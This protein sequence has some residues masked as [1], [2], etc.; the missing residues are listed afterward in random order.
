MPEDFFL[1]ISIVFIIIILFFIYYYIET[2]LD[3]HIYRKA[4]LQKIKTVT[5]ETLTNLNDSFCDY[6]RSDPNEMKT[7]AS[8]LT[9]KNCMNTKCTIWAS[10]KNTGEKS[11]LVGNSF[12][13][14]FKTENGV[15]LDIDTYY[16][17]NNCYGSNCN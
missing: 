2:N 5:I 11:C 12:G 3:K 8:K 4:Q 1:I 7:E 17:M 9:Q 14:N 6:Y 15:N 16:F 10:N 13:P